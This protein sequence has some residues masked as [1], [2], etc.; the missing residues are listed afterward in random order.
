MYNERG[1]KGE[2]HLPIPTPAGTVA[3]ASREY[4][5]ILFAEEGEKNINAKPQRIFSYYLSTDGGYR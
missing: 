1:S 2:V 3:T 4:A 5:G